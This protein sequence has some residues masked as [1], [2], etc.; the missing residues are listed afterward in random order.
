MHAGLNLPSQHEW[1]VGGKE[2]GQVAK[3]LAA[4]GALPA[5]ERAAVA[6]VHDYEASWITR[7]QPQGKDFQF[8]ELAF[9]WYEA[10]R[11]LGLDVDFVGPGAPLAGYK[12]V[13]VPTMPYVSVAAAAAFTAADGLV[14]YGPRTGSKTRSF[15][16]PANLPPGPLQELT[17]V[18]VTQVSALRPGLSE[19]VFGAVAGTAIRWREYLDGTAEVVAKFEKGDLAL[20]RKGRHHYLACWPDERLLHGTIRKLANDAK[21]ET[22]ELPDDVRIRRRGDLTFAFNYGPAPREVKLK[23][24]PVLGSETIPPQGLAVWR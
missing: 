24:E 22:H 14:L 13:L 10:A 1:S 4:L 19:A 2:A 20:S 21:L 23:G 9:R 6:I 11:R 7:I 8:H 15:S 18:R 5:S 16:I 17:G 3:E 12:L